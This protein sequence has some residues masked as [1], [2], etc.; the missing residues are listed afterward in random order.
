MTA[1]PTKFTCV[2]LLADDTGVPS[3]NIVIA[4]GCKLP[5]TG[6]QYLRPSYPA[7]AISWYYVPPGTPGDVSGSAKFGSA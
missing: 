4:P 2:I 3:S 6:T 5:P 1:A 7:T